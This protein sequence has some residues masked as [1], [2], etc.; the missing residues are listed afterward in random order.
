MAKRKKSAD[1]FG[2]CYI[3]SLIIAIILPLACICGIITRIKE[4]KYVAAIIRFLVG[5]NIVWII[6]LIFMI[7]DKKICRILNI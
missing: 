7:K 5:W 3:A 2:L 6:D 1:Y 4:R